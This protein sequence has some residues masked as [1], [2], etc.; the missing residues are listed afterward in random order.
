VIDECEYIT[1]LHRHLDERLEPLDDPEL[2]AF[3]DAHPHHLEAFAA[4]RADFEALKLVPQSA[5]E[6]ATD[7][8]RAPATEPTWQRSFRHPIPAAA[9]VLL[10]ALGWQLR[11]LTMT[12]DSD[13]RHQPTRPPRILSASIE[14]LEATLRPAAFYTVRDPMVRTTTFTLEAYEGRSE[15]R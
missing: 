6:S 14:E 5:G 13:N 4:M 9:A 12:N 3:L 10:I 11:A 15:L 2:V 1:R 8:R 7:I